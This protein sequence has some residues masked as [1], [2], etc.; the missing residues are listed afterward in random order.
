MRLRLTARW[1]KSRKFPDA[2]CDRSKRLQH[3]KIERKKPLRPRLERPFDSVR[4]R[5]KVRNG[6]ATGDG[7]MR[8]GV[9]GR[10]ISFG[11]VVGLLGVFLAAWL[12]I[13]GGGFP[14]AS[15]ATAEPN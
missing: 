6:A 10:R 5:D 2:F 15:Q 9:W 11:L 3:R 4:R 1:T 8:R 13:S 7:E 14:A 12:G